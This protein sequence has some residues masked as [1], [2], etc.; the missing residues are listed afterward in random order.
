M[1]PAHRAFHPLT[2][3]GN[4]QACR[5]GRR[6]LEHIIGDH[7]R[8]E[9]ELAEIAPSGVTITLNVRYLTPQF[10]VSS[11]P[12]AWIE[13]YTSNRLVM[14]DP[15][16]L[17][18]TLHTGRIRWSE[19]K[20]PV[21]EFFGSVV[22]DQAKKHGLHYGA[23]VVM[24]N[25]QSNND[26]CAIFAARPD[27]ELTDP[28]I[29]YLERVLQATMERVGK[30]AGLSDAELETLRDIASGLSHREIAELRDIAVDTVK[31]RLERVRRVL[32]ARNATHAVSIATK[33]GLILDTPLF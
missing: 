33:R 4:G 19:I 12:D 23:S 22:F 24:K 16:A 31:K 2:N 7:H 5:T 29:D 27:R 18:A 6:M 25:A 15:A 10:Y 8:V 21:Y 14:F 17:W 1:P 26:R 20:G 3:M 32:G 11:Y 30:S 9:A 28:E 13:Q